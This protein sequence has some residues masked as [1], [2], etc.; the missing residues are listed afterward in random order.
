MAD[1][2]FIAVLV[3]FL[4][5]CALYVR[6]CERLIASADDDSMTEASR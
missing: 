3:G 6:G 5:L 2:V 1:I 4:G